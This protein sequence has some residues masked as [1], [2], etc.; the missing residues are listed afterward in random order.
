MCA[1]YLD[2]L[3][4]LTV[5]GGYDEATFQARF[6]ELQDQSD[7]YI[8]VVIEGLLDS[9]QRTSEHAAVVNESYL[10]NIAQIHP[11]AKLLVQQHSLSR[12]N[13]YG[14]AENVAISKTLWWIQHTEVSDWVPSMSLHVIIFK[15]I[16]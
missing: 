8:V 9:I 5:V 3:G 16:Y 13:S 1:G 2:L 15:A 7:T 12:R 14:I 11:R 10:I 4:Q 6:K